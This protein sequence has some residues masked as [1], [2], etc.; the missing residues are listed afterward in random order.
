[1]CGL[2]L[3]LV[4][5]FLILNRELWNN[6]TKMLFFGIWMFLISFLRKNQI[7]QK[8][9]HYF[10]GSTLG[11]F[12]AGFSFSPSP[13]LPLIF[14]A[15]LPLIWL[16][17]E[18]YKNKLSRRWFLFY[19]FNFF[20]IWNLWTT[21]W[22]AN[23]AFF[24]G[25]VGMSINALLMTLTVWWAN[26]IHRKVS[27][28]WYYGL[29]FLACWVSFEFIHLRWDLSW[30]WLTLGNTLAEWPII[31]QW[32]EYTGVLGGTIWILGANYILFDVFRQKGLKI[33]TLRTRLFIKWA[34]W[35]FVPVFLSIGIY[36]TTDSN[37]PKMEAVVINP[38]IEPHFDKFTQDD[39]SQWEVYKSLMEEALETDPSVILLPETIF[40]RI[41]TDNIRLNPNIQR[42]EQ[43]LQDHTSDARI[44]LGVTSFRIFDKDHV[45]ARSSIR[46]SI[47][48]DQ[49]E[50]DWEVYN[51]AVL[52][53][54]DTVP[55]YHK[56]K[57]VPGAEIFPYRTVLFFLNS[58]IDK[59]G[60][61]IY[62]YGRPESQNVFKWNNIA[63][64]PII[65]YE[66][67]YGEFTR[68]YVANGATVLG[69]ITNDGW[70][71]NTSGHVQHYDF[72]ALRA[73]E[74]R[75][76][77]LRSANMGYC[78]AFDI[79]GDAIVE[80]NEY[81]Q[82]AVIPVTVELNDSLT[83]YALWGDYLGRFS[84][85]LVVFFSLKGIVNSIVRR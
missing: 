60:G 19:V 51:S 11:G 50:Y 54:N 72:A 20:L 70:W 65:C 30:P 1:M 40:D 73:I 64:G 84:L 55:I 6:E 15:F 74:Y 36:Y 79:K 66:S 8:Q 46:K 80:P 49:S 47:S 34:A 2:V 10:L 62:G 48:K 33:S 4:S 9:I 31:A 85:F 41:N 67:V 28:E 44:L 22:I 12:I 56:Q 58:I 23:T 45:P 7:F 63:L 13:F 17:N 53:G 32:Y 29:V 83:F 16:E 69:I 5:G 52:L 25:M 81:G 21:F 3:S 59:L 27:V 37:G 24:P 57:L 68:K 76:S 18:R 77:I 42:S 75:R 61:S 35:I 39:I 82:R 26:A 78:G 38:N 71:G 43:L 14:V